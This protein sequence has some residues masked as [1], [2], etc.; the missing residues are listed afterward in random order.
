M[1]KCPKAAFDWVDRSLM[2]KTI[3]NRIDPKNNPGA[4][5]ILEFSKPFVE[6][7]TPTSQTMDQTKHSKQLPEF[8]KAV[9]MRQ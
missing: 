5:K 9:L 3:R 6:I 2:F 8:Y 1:Q 4:D 7:P